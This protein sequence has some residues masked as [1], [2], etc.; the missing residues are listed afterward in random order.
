[1]KWQWWTVTRMPG[2][3]NWEVPEVRREL[4]VVAGTEGGD[5]AVTRHLASPYGPRSHQ[6]LRLRA[7]TAVVCVTLVL[8][9]AQLSSWELA[10]HQGHPQ[11]STGDVAGEATRS[12]AGKGFGCTIN[13]SLFKIYLEATQPALAHLWLLKDVFPQHFA[14]PAL[15]IR[16]SSWKM[17][18][19]SPLLRLG[20][21]LHVHKRTH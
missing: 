2:C 4:R 17:Q 8:L 16:E 19:P 11:L 15:F 12:P 18:S 21:C 6:V 20:A 5:R 1:M 14:T 3:L 13:N 10:A 7:A 9:P